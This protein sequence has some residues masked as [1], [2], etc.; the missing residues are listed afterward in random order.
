MSFSTAPRQV[1]E[2]LACQPVPPSRPV[3]VIRQDV[4]AGL[5][6][7]R[8]RS[9]PPKYF[10]DARGSVLFDQLCDTPEYYPTRTEDALLEARAA[11]IVAAARPAN[12]VELGAGACR[13]TRRL[14]DACAG[15]GMT[16]SYV[17]FDVC[18]EILVDSGSTLVSD[19]PWLQIRALVGDYHAGL[20][21]LPLF[22]GPTLYVFLG[23]TIGNFEHEEAVAFLAEVARRMGPEDRL[24]VGADRFKDPG[25]LHAAYNDGAGLTAAFNL[26]VLNVLNRE[27]E[28]NFDVDAFRHHACYNPAER[29]V[30]MYLTSTR[31]QRVR[32]EA[33]D[34]ELDLDEGEGV[35][36]E[37]SRKFTRA[38]LNGLLNE[39]GLAVD[40]HYEAPRGMF[41]LVLARTVEQTRM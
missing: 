25:L 35:R 5:V 36:T 17:P 33:L 7:G 34:E 2:R 31:N 22:G 15:H 10:Y 3:P 39:S 8:P 1:T 9:L 4:L 32:L 11:E 27:L 6:N 38:S 29:R 40:H 30:E 24:L 18:E 16:A 20:D 23:G 12:I 21:H 13:K 41:S 19:Y 37:I 14:F 28:G 26:N